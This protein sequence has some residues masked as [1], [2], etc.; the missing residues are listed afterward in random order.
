MK[1]CPLITQASILDD[2]EL[3]VRELDDVE[4]SA[5]GAQAAPGKDDEIFINPAS[6]PRSEES[7]IDEIAPVVPI[8]FLA[9]SYRGRVEC[10]GEL[11]RFH[12]DELRAC[13]IERLI[14]GEAASGKDAMAGIRVEL[15]KAW[16]SQRKSGSELFEL[17]KE[18]RERNEMSV[19]EL[20]T[21][22][23]R[24]IDDLASF[25]R[26]SSEEKQK[27]IDAISLTLDAKTDEIERKID[28]GEQE[29]RTF[30][31]EVSGWK[32]ALA[33][34]LETIE[35]GLGEHRKLVREL[36]DNHTGIMNLVEGQKKSIEVEEKKRR[37]TE[38]RM[39]NNGG[40]MAYHN[41]QYEKA[42]E[43]F[44]KA[45]DLDPAMTEAYNNLGLTYTEINE[46]E[47]A[48]EA[49]KTAISLS[50]ELAA[51]YN[52]LGYVF[53]RLGSYREAIEMYNE[54][55]GRSNDSSSAYTNLGNAYYK[56]EKIED[57][58]DAW[59]KALALDPANEKARRNLKRFHAEVK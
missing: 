7:L 20:K 59:K 41:G 15:D 57:A 10:L 54:A 38:A 53:Y 33:K 34:N 9:K 5:G 26:A 2:K 48:T 52:N 19:M 36:S 32:S 12:D 47:K 24:K 22:V 11:C 45:I 44:K 23:E 4:P 58:I 16:E 18:M 55:I 29:F 3:L 37:S 28:A 50:P 40:V 27:A 21:G 35:T 6:K 42:L 46:E 13:R 1:I 25:M 56:L 8:R 43:L 14:A 39:I 31:D 17:M 30:R 51:A 49:F